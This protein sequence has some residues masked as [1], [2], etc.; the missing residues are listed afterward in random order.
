MPHFRRLDS[1]SPWYPIVISRFAHR[2]VTSILAETDVYCI[3]PYQ[4]Y[5]PTALSVS[6]RELVYG[7]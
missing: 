4:P 2:I 3:Q 5:S 1:N 7:N 6:R